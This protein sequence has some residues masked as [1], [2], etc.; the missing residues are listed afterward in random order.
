MDTI[1]DNILRFPLL[2]ATASAESILGFLEIIGERTGCDRLEVWQFY[3]KKNS[4]EGTLLSSRL[5]EWNQGSNACVTNPNDA[6]FSVSDIR[7]DLLAALQA[8]KCVNASVS[9]LPESEQRILR[10]QGVKSVCLAGIFFEG[11]LWGMLGLEY[12]AKEYILSAAEEKSFRQFAQFLGVTVQTMQENAALRESDAFFHNVMEAT[13]E[14]LWSVDSR[15]CF[16]SISG[17]V[18]G[19]CGYEPEE[20][21]GHPWETVFGP[22]D[23]ALATLSDN[24]PTFREVVHTLKRKDGRPCFVQTSA[25]AFFDANGG[26]SW[27]MGSSV[28]VTKS[29]EIEEKLRRANEQREFVNRQLAEAVATANQMA[30]EAQMASATKSEFL[31]NMSHEIRTPMSAI[32]GMIHL[33]LKTELQPGQRD[34]LDKAQNAAQ[35]LLRIINDILDFSKIEAGKMELEKAEFSLESVLRSAT[36]MITEKASRKGVEVLVS[37][38][39]DSCLYLVGDQLRLTQVLINLANNAIKFTDEGEVALTVSVKKKDD[40]RTTLLFSVTDT[41][42]GMT[43]DQMNRVFSPFSQA[44]TST[45]RRYGGTGLGLALCKNIVVLL[46]GELWCESK[47]GEGSAFHFTATFDVPKGRS[48]SS[49]GLFS[50]K[51]KDLRFLAVDDNET[52]LMVLSGLLMDFGCS[53][54]RQAASGIEALAIL[55]KEGAK[56]FDIVLLDWKMPEM[57]GVQTLRRIRK[58]MPNEPLAIVMTTAYDRSELAAKLHPGEVSGIITKPFTPSILLNAIQEAFAGDMERVVL[59]SKENIAQDF[60]RGVNILLTEDNEL[61]QL[62]AS[63]ILGQA[64]ARMTIANNGKEALE[65][66]ESGAHFDLVLMD[67]QMP[68]MDGFTAVKHIRKNPRFEGL[69]IIAMTAHAMVGDKEKSLRGGMNDHVTKPI[70]PEELFAVIGKWCSVNRNYAH[71]EETSEDTLEKVLNVASALSKIGGNRDLFLKILLKAKEDVPVLLAKLRLL[72][73]SGDFNGVAGTLRILSGLLGSIGAQ[74]AMAMVKT[75]EGTP[76]GE[77]SLDTITNLESNWK[78]IAAALQTLNK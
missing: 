76:V 2:P 59:H 55:E 8:S 63:E 73:A 51:L 50:K 66:L 74:D 35:S 42:I 16:A 46:G 13:G 54:V 43:R 40:S 47:L 68:V 38:A 21:V 77:I 30:V 25:K 67:I 1:I 61:N 23:A 32:L 72:Q 75:L 12:L 36:D 34:Y 57:D 28:D 15:M 48:V 5:Y 64:G 41:G 58:L 17:R 53:A 44:D 18:L 52:S 27:L 37:I 69:P 11:A 78:A 19:V 26:V 9:D 62:V 31:A 49:D 24:T 6:P 71:H 4:P 14:M 33:V 22:I 39:P 45:T 56:A 29:R 70:N 60:I 20:L 3:R 65:I 10:E 7:P